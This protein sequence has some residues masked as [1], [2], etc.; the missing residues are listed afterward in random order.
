VWHVPHCCLNSVA[1]SA[2]FATGRAICALAMPMASIAPQNASP[3]A[4]T[5]RSFVM[6]ITIGVRRL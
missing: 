1:P 2:G 3:I 6:H 4:R 5:A